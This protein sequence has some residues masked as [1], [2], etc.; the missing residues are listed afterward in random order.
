MLDIQKRLEFIQKL[1]DEGKKTIVIN[2]DVWV[3]KTYTAK[4]ICHTYFIDEPTYKV[5]LS[6]GNLRLRKPEEF[7]SSIKNYP[8]EALSKC[9]IIVYDDFW[10]SEVTS[11]YIEK[12]LYRI[13]RRLDK[14][15]VTIITT[16][17]W[18]KKWKE[19]EPRITSRL[20]ENAVFINIKWP[21]LRKENTLYY[22]IE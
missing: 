10:S 17:L 11:A 5:Y 18:E 14:W 22:N 2:W 3:G 16:N 13:N 19:F 12:T 1:I 6:S 21:D 20:S 15:L 8:L 9:D 7:W 4:N